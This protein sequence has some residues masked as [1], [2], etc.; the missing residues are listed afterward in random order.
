VKVPKSSKKI[1]K[2]VHHIPASLDKKSES[3]KASKK[4]AENA[5]KRIKKNGAKR[6]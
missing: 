2:V 5:R 4:A 3:W 1:A 6:R